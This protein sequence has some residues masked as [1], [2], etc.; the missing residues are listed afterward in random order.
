[1]SNKGES[2]TITTG[3]TVQLKYTMYGTGG[4]QWRTWASKVGTPDELPFW[5]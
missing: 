3:A 2:A 4:K 1:M 5:R